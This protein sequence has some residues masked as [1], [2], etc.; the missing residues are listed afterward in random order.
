M[1][2]NVN[3]TLVHNEIK[4]ISEFTRFCNELSEFWPK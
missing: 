4:S 1:E 3:N 2:I